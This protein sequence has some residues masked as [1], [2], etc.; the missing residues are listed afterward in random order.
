MTPMQMLSNEIKIFAKKLPYVKEIS[1]KND[2]KDVKTDFLKMFKIKTEA[3]NYLLGL[4]FFYLNNQPQTV[5]CSIK[6]KGNY[7][8]FRITEP[9]DVETF[10]EK[11]VNITNE[12]EEQSINEIIEIIQK[13]FSLLPRN[14]RS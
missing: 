7:K 14:K 12:I 4:H 6:F 1:L 8:Y 3:G 10:R 11:I 2:R 13:G 5:Q 9:L